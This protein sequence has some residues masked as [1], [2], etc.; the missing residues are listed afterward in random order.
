QHGSNLQPATARA[1]ASHGVSV[2]PTLDTRY[3]LNM[4]LEDPGIPEVIR[5]RA[6]ATAHGR[7]DAYQHALDAGVIV[8]A[9][10]DSGT[11][12]VPHGALA[13]EIRLMHEGGLP[14]RQAI[15]SATWLAASEVGLPSVVGT[16]APGAQADLLL[17][18]AD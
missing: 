6:Q 1:L 5:T 14:V 16:L 11:T 7:A 2:T 10:T 13:T 12:F 17:L 3:F 8:T 18:E 15:A 9:G 4:H